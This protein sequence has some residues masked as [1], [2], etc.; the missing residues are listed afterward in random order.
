MKRFN[1]GNE[2]FVSY[3]F[4]TA[5]QVKAITEKRCEMQEPRRSKFSCSAPLKTYCDRSNGAC[6]K[7]A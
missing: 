6:G 5:K 2:D 4:L 3:P 7:L 1:D